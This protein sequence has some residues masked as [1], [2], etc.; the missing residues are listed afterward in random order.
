MKNVISNL[1]GH[2][3]QYLQQIIYR[4]T[5]RDNIEKNDWRSSITKSNQIKS[6]Q[7]YCHIL[8]EEVYMNLTLH[9]L[10][11]QHIE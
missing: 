4:P 6:N 2:W 8:Q 3:K 10:Y 1:C 11:Q 5:N 9:S 7:V